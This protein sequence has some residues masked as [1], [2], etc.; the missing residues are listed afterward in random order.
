MRLIIEIENDLDLVKAQSL[1]GYKNVD[2]LDKARA[3]KRIRKDFAQWCRENTTPINDLPSR[4][5][6]NER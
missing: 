2:L 3:K 5:E 6:K 1:I 4:E